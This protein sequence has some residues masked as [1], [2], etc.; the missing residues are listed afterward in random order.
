MS[1][2]EALID[3]GSTGKAA[4]IEVAFLRTVYADDRVLNAAPEEVQLALK[5]VVIRNALTFRD[6]DLA[7]YRLHRARLLADATVIDRHIAPTEYG[8]SL[9]GNDPFEFGFVAH[10]FR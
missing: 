7:D 5:G 1:H 6:E 9:F 3:N 2:Q 10:S 4:Y 8:E